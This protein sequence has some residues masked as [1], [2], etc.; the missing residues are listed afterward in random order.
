VPKDPKEAAQYGVKIIRVDIPRPANE[1]AMK[2][3]ARENPNRWATLASNRTHGAVDQNRT[4][5]IK[6]AAK[7][8]KFPLMAECFFLASTFIEQIRS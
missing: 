1:Q 5:S 2:T 7:Q 6:W 4:C 8:E 3:A